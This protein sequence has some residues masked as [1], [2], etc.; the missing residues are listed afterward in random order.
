MYLLVGMVIL[1]SFMFF[2]VKCN[3][4]VCIGLLWWI[5]FFMVL[6]RSFGCVC[7]NVSCFGLISRVISVLLIMF[8]VVLKLFII[9][10]WV[11]EMSFVLFNW[12]F[13]LVVCIS[14][15]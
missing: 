10:R 12:L 11:M 4:E 6:G 15:L 14:L 2:M 9:S 1:F 8:M 7:S 3:I 5:S 13:L